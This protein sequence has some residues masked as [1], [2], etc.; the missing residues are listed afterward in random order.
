MHL[1]INEQEQLMSFKLTKG[2]TDDRVPVP[3]LAR[4]LMGKLIGDE[5]Y[6]SQLLFEQLFE[7]DLQLMTK[8]KKNMKNKLMPLFHK[9]LLRIS[10]HFCIYDV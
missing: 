7:Q 10:G 9:L 4:G 2:S 8:I 3:A 5:G 1:L 6:I